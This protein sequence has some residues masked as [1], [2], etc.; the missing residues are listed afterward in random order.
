MQQYALQSGSSMAVELRT[1]YAIY[2][3][4]KKV[5]Q[6]ANLVSFSSVIANIVSFLIRRI[7][8][9]FR[10]PNTSLSLLLLLLW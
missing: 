1:I 5:R 6:I 10:R 4:W 3:V 7:L 2:L 8:K 9:L